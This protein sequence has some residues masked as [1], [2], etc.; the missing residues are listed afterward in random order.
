MKAIIL[1]AGKGTRLHP[2]TESMPKCLIPVDDKVILE[3]MLE[4]LTKNNIDKIILV[5]GFEEDQIKRHFGNYFNNTEIEYI[6]NPK[7]DVH[8]NIYSL[9]L[10]KDHID[11]DILIINADNM[12]NKDILKDIIESEHENA[13]CID[14]TITNLP[15][16]AMKAQIS[17]G[18]LKDV[19]KTISSDAIHGDAIGI[20]KFSKEGAKIYFDEI[21]SCIDNGEA[22]MFYLHAMSKLAKKG[23]D[24]HVISTRGLTWHE[25]D[26]HEDLAKAGELLKRIKEE[27]ANS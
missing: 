24:I 21:A 26:D 9:W 25:V 19:S 4:R 20:Y 5:V 22:N 14:D 18:L 15:E 13:A 7:Y 16:E 1:A 23:F 12:V 3:H 2:I 8:N 17:D 6:T 11:D 10:A 27:E